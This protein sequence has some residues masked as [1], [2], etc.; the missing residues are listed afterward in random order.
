MTIIH[1]ATTLG[2][3]AG[4]GLLRYHQA[5]RARGLDSRILVAAKAPNDL[6]EVAMMH[7]RKEGLV[8]RVLRRCG[9]WRP[10]EERVRGE[11]ARRDSSARGAHYELF[12]VPFSD[13]CPE[14][15]PWIREADVI[16]LHWVAGALDWPRFFSSVTQP[17]VFTLHDQQPYLGGFHY[18][19][20]AARAPH[21]A[22]LDA[23]LRAIKMSA[24]ANHRI[25]VIANSR[26]N[27]DQARAS[28]FFPSTTPASAIYYPL[29]GAT[30]QPRAKAAAKAAFGLPA[31]RRVIG[32][33]C[34][35]LDNPRKGFAFLLAALA[36]LP[37]GLRDEIVLLS[38]GRAPAS[39][40]L[41]GQ[42]LRWIH[43]GYLG[44][45]IAQ[46]AAYAAMD[47]FVAPSQ[48]EAF[49][50]TVLEA[51]AVGT[52][53]VTTEVGGLVEAVA[54][55]CR[56]TPDGPPS[57]DAL[58]QRIALLLTDDARRDR[59][60]CAGREWAAMQHTPAAIGAQLETLY[61]QL[62]R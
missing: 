45:D 31:D 53:V 34:E 14:E 36:R 1:I 17:T 30:F 44:T 58:A 12:S 4:I 55:A 50:L 5:L 20:D 26:W 16:N 6:G 25:G 21:L 47:V 52:A 40:A 3:G 29:D 59:C 32:F 51:Q 28:S 13:F 46:A 43:L 8:R 48:A 27:L 62:A 60:A 9:L 24:I 42:N 61:G 33:A 19:W 18:A 57:A 54:P 22:A 41:A 15:H 23:R 49:G 10:E 38:F 35:N 2:G 11:I 37:E 56:W 39:E 7:R